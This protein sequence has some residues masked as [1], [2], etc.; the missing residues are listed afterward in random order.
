MCFS[1]PYTSLHITFYTKVKEIFKCC[2]YSAIP[3]PQT[4]R[5]FSF[6]WDVVQCPFNKVKVADNL[7]VH[8]WSLH[9]SPLPA[10]ISAAVFANTSQ[11]C[12]PPL[13]YFSLFLPFFLVPF[14]QAETIWISPL[15]ICHLRDPVV[16]KMS[17]EYKDIYDDF[18]YVLFACMTELCLYSPCALMGVCIKGLQIRYY[19]ISVFMTRIGFLELI[20]TFR[21][22][23]TNQVRVIV[24]GRYALLDPSYTL[25]HWRFSGNSIFLWTLFKPRGNISLLILIKINK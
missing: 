15:R 7:A 23:C 21:L 6:L 18:K 19:C 1:V 9:P 16:M 3:E 12:T 4:F 13:M 5:S 20:I 17:L 14:W 10:G 25:E 24:I 22:W 8:T 11:V 2:L